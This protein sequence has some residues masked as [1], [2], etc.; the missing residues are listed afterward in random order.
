MEGGAGDEV[1]LLM[2]GVG[3][4]SEVDC[5]VFE[6]PD[7]LPGKA[8][9]VEVLAG[10]DGMRVERIVSHGHTTPDGEWYDQEADEWVSL[11]QGEATL[12]WADGSKTELEAGDSLFIEAHRRHRVAWTSR[13][14]P[15][16]WI[17]VHGDL[18][19]A[20]RR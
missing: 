11:L 10:G 7:G 16:I 1:Y 3:V 9:F 15:F 18:S 19:G 14:P 13:E 8:E 17:A 12:V 6:L 5:N 2:D 4:M 20:G